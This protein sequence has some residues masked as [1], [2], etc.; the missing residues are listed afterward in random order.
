MIDIVVLALLGLAGYKG[1]KD[2]VIME[3]FSFLAVVVGL[4]ASVRLLHPAME[5]MAPHARNAGAALPFLMFALVFA[6]VFLIIFLAGKMIKSAMKL[7]VMGTVDQFAGAF[8]GVLKAGFLIGI[9]FWL[10]QLLNIAKVFP[11]VNDSFMV[12]I[13]SD[14]ASTTI[15]ILNHAFPVKEIFEKV[16]HII[17]GTKNGSF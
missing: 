6:A 3:V 9:L 15:H 17:Q 2:G 8:L 12:S 1:F 16:N 4:I 5:L 10:G 7:T 13:T 11:I 14:F